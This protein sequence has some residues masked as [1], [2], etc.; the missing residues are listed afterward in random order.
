MRAVNVLLGAP[1]AVAV[2]LGSLVA[3]GDPNR[4]HAVTGEETYASLGVHPVAANMQRATVKRKRA[5][6][7]VKAT[8]VNGNRVRVHVKTNA[9]RTVVR[10]YSRTGKKL[11]TKTLKHSSSRK[12][13]RVTLPK[14]ANA[15]VRV[16]VSSK[17][18]KL[19]K[20]LILL[21]KVKATSVR[22]FSPSSVGSSSPS[23]FAV[24]VLALVNKARSVGRKCGSTTYSAAPAL[25]HN[26]KLSLAAQRH[27]SDMAKNDYFSHDG[28]NGSSFADRATAANYRWSLIGEN[29]AA[30]YSTAGS[31][32]KGWLASPGHCE[33]VMNRSYK[34]LGVGM[35]KHSNGRYGT[36]W[37]Q[38]FGKPR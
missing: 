9:K 8:Q 13:V 29:I 25:K 4:S 3:A 22:R 2:G 35:A 15:A 19:H 21:S 1:L 12:W 38:M 28:R 32:M 11:T 20:R 27:S 14:S 23:A 7:S 33:N 30:G 31:V 18:V 34:E 10:A 26:S 24:E 6:V 16:K 36:Y 17:R 37:T 5:S